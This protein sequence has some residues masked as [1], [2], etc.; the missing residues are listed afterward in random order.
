MW[1][2][3]KFLSQMTSALS[4]TKRICLDLGS[5]GNATIL[6]YAILNY[7]YNEELK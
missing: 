3:M 7:N 4:I 2:I 6:H 1:S 5:V